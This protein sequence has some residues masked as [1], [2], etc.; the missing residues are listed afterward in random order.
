MLVEAEN[1][2]DA[3]ELVRRR[4]G[5]DRLTLSNYVVEKGVEYN[6]KP[7]KGRVLSAHPQGTIKVSVSLDE[8]ALGIT[9]RS[10]RNLRNEV[11][12][13]LDHELIVLETPTSEITCGYLIIDRT[14]NEA[15]FTGDGFRT[16]GGGEGGAGYRAAQA[17]LNVF[18]V[19]PYFSEPLDFADAYAGN[20][21]AVLSRLRELAEEAISRL[22]N[23]FVRPS[24]TKASYMRG[25]LR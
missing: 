3:R 6:P 15:V 19:K 10:L 21:E 25:F 2:E 4:L 22:G 23:R 12:R 17:Y 18:C 7:I 11:A 13:R 16:D 24:E 1:P 14:A 20:P 5:D 8:N 9:E